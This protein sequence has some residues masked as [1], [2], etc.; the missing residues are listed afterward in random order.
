MVISISLIT[1]LLSALLSTPVQISGRGR[2]A[3]LELSSRMA[4][5]RLVEAHDPTRVA[6]N[7]VVYR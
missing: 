5:P 2:S 6:G 4:V 1:S 3:C 7:V